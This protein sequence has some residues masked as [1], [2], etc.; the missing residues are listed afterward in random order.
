M[1]AIALATT[2]AMASATTFKVSPGGK[3][4]ATAGKT[5]LLDNN[6]HAKLS[7]KSAGAKGR[8]KKGSHLAGK[9]I[10]T[11]TTSSFTKCI[12]PAGLTFKVKQSGTWTLNLTKYSSKKGGVATGYIGNIKAVLSGTD[13]KATVTGEADATISNRSHELIVAP[14]KKS[15]HKLKI[16]KVS[17][18]LTLINNGD[19]SG[20]TGTYKLSPKQ[21]VS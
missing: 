17:G 21:K 2:T 1:A 7:C 11:I 14:V 4:T 13:C 9:D 8:L 3:Y 6:T 5:T 15:G 12:G 18:C 19:T 16:S 10:A 20:F